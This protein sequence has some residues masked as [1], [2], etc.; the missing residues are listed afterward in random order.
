MSEDNKALAR[1]FAEE[2]M[3]KGN[4]ETAEELLASEYK[5]YDPA[6]PE[7]IEGVEGFKENLNQ[8]RTA[9][10]DA[11]STVE[12]VLVDGDKAVVRWN[13]KGTNKGEF[14]GNPATDKEVEITGISI[15]RFEEG[16]IAESWHNYDMLGM[17]KQLGAL[18]QQEDEAA[19]ETEEKPEE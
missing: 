3:S 5:G 17:M 14:M 7:P 18:P 2:V 8:L 1:R 13:W 9:F 4:M 11:S 12:D 19:E 10:P 15:H 16:K 6:S